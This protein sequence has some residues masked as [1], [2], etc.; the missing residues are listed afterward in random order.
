MSY[1]SVFLARSLRELFEAW[2][3]YEDRQVGL[4]DR[5]RNHVYKKIRNIETYPERYPNKKGNFRET[6]LKSLPYLII[7]RINKRQKKIVLVSI[8]HTS[9]NPFDKYKVK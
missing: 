6:R 2:E 4:G 7:Y 1:P 8:F 9:R 3:W 5:F